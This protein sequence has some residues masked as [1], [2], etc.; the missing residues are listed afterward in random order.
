LRLVRSRYFLTHPYWYTPQI[1]GNDNA[2]TRTALSLALISQHSLYIDDYASAT[3]DK[4]RI[5]GRFLC[6]KAPGTS[7]AAVPGIAMGYWVMK[8]FGG[9][10]DTAYS[11]TNTIMYGKIFEPSRPFKLLTMIEAMSTSS[12]AT[13]LAAVGIMYPAL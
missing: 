4:A 2:V 3:A 11:P 13:A 6:D 7:F 12:V 9:V 1:A 5:S 10:G 8:W